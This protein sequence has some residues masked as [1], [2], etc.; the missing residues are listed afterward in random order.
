MLA[1]RGKR[2]LLADNGSEIGHKC[3]PYVTLYARIPKG[4]AN[5]QYNNVEELGKARRTRA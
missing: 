3:A 2:L 5:S 4:R 1:K